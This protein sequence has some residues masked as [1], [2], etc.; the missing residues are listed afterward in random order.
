VAHSRRVFVIVSSLVICAAAALPARA[1][2]YRKC[3]LNE[4]GGGWGMVTTEP[5]WGGT[6]RSN[7]DIPSG[8]WPANPDGF[9]F[10][11]GHQPAPDFTHSW[12]LVKFDLM[13]LI[14]T[15]QRATG[16]ATVSFD[17]WWN[18]FCYAWLEH[19]DPDVAPFI[20]GSLAIYEIPAGKV[21]GSVIPLPGSSA[22]DPGGYRYAFNE[23][24][25]DSITSGGTDEWL[26]TCENVGEPLVLWDGI[27]HDDPAPGSPVGRYIEFTIPQAVINRWIAHPETYNGLLLAAIEEDWQFRNGGVYASLWRQGGTSFSYGANYLTFDYALDTRVPGDANGDGAVTD[28]DYTIWAD[29]YGEANAGWSGGD[30]NEDGLVSDADYTIWADNYGR[31]GNVPEPATM[32]VLVIASVA[33]SLR[34]RR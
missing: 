23:A 8:A 17:I 10:G 1:A 29:H 20:P 18:H 34:R 16:D 21:P 11:P 2:E 28:A 7:N 30:W 12:G 19:Y 6:T 14:G 24:S 9:M 33:G 32:V 13:G 31:T 25:Y 3:F 4:D 5:D 22:S 26:P 27:E 15:S